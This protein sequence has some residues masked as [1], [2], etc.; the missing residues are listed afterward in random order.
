[1]TNKNEKLV[2]FS[3]KEQLFK[4]KTDKDFKEMYRKYYPKL[5]YYISKISKDPQKAEDITT[6]A[7]ITSLNKIEKYDKDKAQFSTWLFTIGKNLSLQQL[8]QDKKS[9]SMDV[10]Y[11]A[12]G[13]TM[14]DFI[15]NEGETKEDAYKIIDRKADIMKKYIYEL[16]EPYKT[17]IEMRELKKMAYKDIA[18]HLDKNL[19]TIKSQIRNGRHILISKTENEFKKIDRIQK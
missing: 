13:T 1:M 18:N 3:E 9:V 12:D 8:K 16:K 10:E 19:S 14:K 4:E 17:V 15:K 11:D 6:E 5:L 2:M 7:F